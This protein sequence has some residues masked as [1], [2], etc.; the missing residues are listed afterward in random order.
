M[1]PLCV[2][3]VAIACQFAFF[4][5]Y[6]L[7]YF[8]I[9]FCSSFSLCFSFYLFIFL[10]LLLLSSTPTLFSFP[11]FLPDALFSCFC[12]DLFPNLL[13]LCRRLLWSSAEIPLV[14]YFVVFVLFALYATEVYCYYPNLY[15]LYI[16]LLLWIFC[17]HFPLT[18][19]PPVATT[20]CL[21]QHLLCLS[22]ISFVNCHS[23]FLYFGGSWPLGPCYCIYWATAAEQLNW[24]ENTLYTGLSGCSAYHVQQKPAIKGLIPQ[25]P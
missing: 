10:L 21:S 19:L 4:P 8:Y 1:I 11:Y 17:L 13:A 9:H 14:W 24:E 2:V 16:S 18:V 22:N 20:P 6:W 5:D 7:F 12:F 3:F 25:F 23:I 15:C